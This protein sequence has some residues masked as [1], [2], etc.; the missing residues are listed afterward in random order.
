M[1]VTLN[2]KVQHAQLLSV[3]I[4]QHRIFSTECLAAFDVVAGTPGTPQERLFSGRG[5]SSREEFQEAA[6]QK[7]RRDRRNVCRQS[8]H[9][10][11]HLLE[12]LDDVSILACE[13]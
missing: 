13:F 5:A 12:K 6:Y 10:K 8:F 1:L 7:D 3:G 11:S 9:S 2:H 4:K